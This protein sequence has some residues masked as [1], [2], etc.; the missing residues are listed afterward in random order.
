MQTLKSLKLI[1]NLK[2]LFVII[3]SLISTF[4]CQY[5]GLTA[6]FPLTIIGIAVVFPV[7]FS[8]SGAYKRRETALRYYGA[9]KA[10]GRAIFFASRDW[11][12][13]DSAPHQAEL[14]VILVE[15]LSG[16]REFFHTVDVDRTKEENLVYSKFSELSLFIKGFRNREMTTG[17]VSRT[18]QYLS[19]MVDAF[20][21]MKHIY[22]YRTPRTLRAYSKIFIFLVPVLY[23]PYFA[24]LAKDI[25][26]GLAVIT[27]ILFSV[28]LVSL[29]NIQEQ[30]ENP[31]DQ[32]GED[33]IKINAEKFIERLEL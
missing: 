24:D 33:D 1:I 7:V 17:E 28:V 10:H 29:D 22:Q 8:I 21:S 4:G 20:E 14:K 13:G 2:T 3:M 31:F 25:P 26:V 9:L 12:K 23:G 5:F 27:P 16:C 18:N 15:L 32:F 11:T 19:K 6:K 30:L